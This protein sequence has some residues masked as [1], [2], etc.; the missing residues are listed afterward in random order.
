MAKKKRSSSGAGDT[1][2]S[3]LALILAASVVLAFVKGN[4]VRS[5]SDVI[6][7]FQGHAPSVSE[8][9]DNLVGD[10]VFTWPDA[11]A[12]RPTPPGGG[13][14]GSGGESGSNGGAE[15]DNRPEGSGVYHS[16]SPTE[17]SNA[18]EN[19]VVVSEFSSVDYDRSEWRHWDNITSCWTVRDE[20]LHRQAEPGSLTLLDRND[21]PTDSVENACTISG[22]EWIDPFT[23]DV[24]TNPSDLD[25]DHVIPLGYAARAGG[26]QWDDGT[27]RDYANSLE[28]G[29][30]L[31]VSASA[32]RSKGDRGPANWQPR[33]SYH[34]D[35]AKHWIS[36]SDS[37]DLEVS[38]EDYDALESMLATC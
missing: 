29:H 2:K 20:V 3:I 32:N 30:L 27:K 16:W 23:G 38:Q 25:I 11:N 18:L 34:C 14:N 24:F 12:P 1:F 7:V 33:E 4:N 31:A 37:W 26:Q 15:N 35:Y 36:V 17:A 22:G 5:P 28:E 21:S 19:L 9:F 6:G 10:G 8:F 13:G